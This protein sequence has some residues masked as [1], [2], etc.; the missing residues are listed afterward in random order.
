MPYSMSDDENIFWLIVTVITEL[1]I[2]FAAIYFFRST[3]K[4]VKGFG[5]GVDFYTLSTLIIICL[6]SLIRAT[7]LAI[8]YTR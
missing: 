8:I 5:S 3:I 4:Y 2:F 1:L 7:I 6:S